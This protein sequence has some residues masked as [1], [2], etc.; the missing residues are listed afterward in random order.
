MDARPTLRETGARIAPGDCSIE[1]LTVALQTAVADEIREVRRLLDQLAE[2]LIGDE[3]FAST[4]L[5]Q[6]QVFDLLAQYADETAS[7]LDRLAG[8][9]HP[10]AAVAPV[11]LGVVR[12]RLAAALLSSPA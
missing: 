10:Q 2:L 8:G 6:L 11:R 5:E 7:V 12:E 3:H 9:L 1:T 4:Y